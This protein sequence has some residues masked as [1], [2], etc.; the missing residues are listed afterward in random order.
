MDAENG[1]AST[2][3]A[4]LSSV[5]NFELIICAS[6]SI[7][8]VGCCQ[9]GCQFPVGAQVNKDRPSEHGLKV[10]DGPFSF[11]EPKGD[12][13]QQRDTGSPQCYGE[14]PQ[15]KCKQRQQAGKTFF[16]D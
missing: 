3:S 1:A 11:K 10:P 16:H 14:S 9:T 13:P 12:V 6:L 8:A 15:H 4:E 5:S 2:L 7:H